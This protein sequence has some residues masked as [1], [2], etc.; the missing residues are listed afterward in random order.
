MRNSDTIG[1]AASVTLFPTTF[2]KK[3][4]QF[5]KCRTCIRDKFIPPRV[6]PLPKRARFCRGVNTKSHRLPPLHKVA[7]MAYPCAHTSVNI[8]VFQ[9]FKKSYSTIVRKFTVRNEVK[10]IPMGFISSNQ[11][12]CQIGRESR[13]TY[14]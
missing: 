11:T 14:W 4:N 12:I 5:L 7:K 6:D 10:K 9:Y 3:R 2:Q 8:H 1:E 13:K